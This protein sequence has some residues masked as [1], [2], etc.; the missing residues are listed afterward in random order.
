MKRAAALAPLSRDHHLALVVA[1][2]L[3]R[4]G[5]GQTEAARGRFVRFLANRSRRRSNQ[6]SEGVTARRCHRET[7]L[8]DVG[9]DRA[10][11]RLDR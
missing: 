9:H 1:R 7:V 11:A 10:E 4:A 5:P 3:A 8:R 6:S 2:E